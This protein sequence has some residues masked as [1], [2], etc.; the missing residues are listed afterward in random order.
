MVLGGLIQDD[1]T[2]AVKKVPLL[3]DIPGLGALFRSNSK[4]R[5]KSNLLVFLRPTVIRNKEDSDTATNRKYKDIW[6]VEISSGGGASDITENFRGRR[7]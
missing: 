5:S 7:N 3:G 4:S 2:D 6:E 1:I